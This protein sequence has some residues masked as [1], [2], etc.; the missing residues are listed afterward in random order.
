MTKMKSWEIGRGKFGS[1]RDKSTCGLEIALDLY[2]R[3]GTVAIYKELV[4]TWL[5]G[6]KGMEEIKKKSEDR[7]KD[8]GL[9]ALL[10]M[11]PELRQLIDEQ[12]SLRLKTTEEH[13]KCISFMTNY[14]PWPY[15]LNPEWFDVYIDA[16]DRFKGD[17]KSTR[18]SSVYSR[19][20]CK[21]HIPDIPELLLKIL[22]GEDLLDRFGIFLKYKD[23][24]RNGE[25]EALILDTQI[26][27]LRT[28]TSQSTEIDELC[29]AFELMSNE[30]RLKKLRC[31]LYSVTQDPWFLSCLKMENITSEKLD[32][33]YSNY[34]KGML[35]NNLNLYRD[36][37]HF[38]FLNT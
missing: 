13:K 36:K 15:P 7:N 12:C 33:I 3:Y 22:A 32:A 23:A 6:A 11:V 27:I 10:D 18:F 28:L 14:I 17:C 21:K 2:E 29:C 25:R 16:L 34:I 35:I 19:K 8:L 9:S 37:F 1:D 4:E 20:F 24:M 26:R 30:I 31:S 5:S 38:L